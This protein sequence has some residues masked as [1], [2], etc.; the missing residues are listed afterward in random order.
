MEYDE[1]LE[2]VY[3][4]YYDC[5]KNKRRKPSAVLFEWNYEI[6][7]GELTRELY[8][9]TYYPTTSVVFPV[10]KPKAREVF[11]ANFRDRIV[12]HLLMMKFGGLIDAEMID[13]TYNCRKDKGVFF[14]QQRLEEEVRRVSHNYTRKAYVLSGDIE[15]FFMAIDTKK[16]WQMVEILIRDKYKGEDIEW[17]LWLF[18]TV[19]MHRPETDCVFH[20]DKRILDALPDNKSQFRSGGYGMPIGNY[21]VQILGNYYLTPFDIFMQVLVGKEGF[22]CRFVDDFKAV[23]PELSLLYKIAVEARVFLW[24]NLHLRLHRK[25]FSIMEVYKGVSFVGCVI[26]PWGR[27]SSNRI[28]GNAFCA[29]HRSYKSAEDMIASYNSYMGFLIRSKTYAIRWKLYLTIPEEIRKQIV[30]IN[31]K[32]YTIRDGLDNTHAEAD[33]LLSGL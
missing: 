8:E 17:W 16:L 5:R 22:Y 3:E 26:K 10:T 6:R 4:A 24:E 28:I 31:M 11:A 20:G 19:V 12:H 1:L 23:I 2:L 29:F 13:D 15:G 9:K 25:K 30:C 27:Y 18:K 7:L 21:Y 32:K 14:A 33:L